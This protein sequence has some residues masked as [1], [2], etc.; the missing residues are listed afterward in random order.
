MKFAVSLVKRF[1]RKPESR[2]TIAQYRREIAR[3]KRQQREQ[4][5][6]IGYLEAHSRDKQLTSTAD[7]EN[8]QRF[9][10]RSVKA[11]T[12]PHWFLCRGLRQARRSF[13]THDLQLGA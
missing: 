3:L 6:K 9:S 2:R 13:A 5:K 4:E 10:A 12:S 8:E 11:A 1:E 7:S